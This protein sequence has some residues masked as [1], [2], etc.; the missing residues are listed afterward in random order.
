MLRSVT[1]GTRGPCFTENPW[2][3]RARLWAVSTAKLDDDNWKQIVD[4]VSTFWK[5]HNVDS[6]SDDAS[7]PGDGIDPRTAIEI[8][9]YVI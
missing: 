6:D 5:R 3:E 2:G 9:W 1:P 8:D 7:I 4:E